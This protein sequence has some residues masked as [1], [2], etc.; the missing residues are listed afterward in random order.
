MVNFYN[1]FLFFISKVSENQIITFQNIVFFFKISHK[2]VLCS[3]SKNI[4]SQSLSFGAK[5]DFYGFIDG[6]LGDVLYF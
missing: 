5:S 6:I 1:S 2:R 4:N 3:I